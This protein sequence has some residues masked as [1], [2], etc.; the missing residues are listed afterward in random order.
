M[1]RHSEFRAIATS[2]RGLRER[3]PVQ[4]AA[5]AMASLGPGDAAKTAPRAMMESPPCLSAPPTPQCAPAARC[6]LTRRGIE[7]RRAAVAVLLV[8]TQAAARR[9]AA[10]PRP[11]RAQVARL[12]HSPE[13]QLRGPRPKRGVGVPQRSHSRCRQSCCYLLPRPGR[14][15]RRYCDRGCGCGLVA[16]SHCASG[17]PR[18]PAVHAPPFSGSLPRRSFHLR[19]RPHLRP[20]SRSRSRLLAP[21]ASV[22]IV[23]LPSRC[24]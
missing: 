11:A 22:A 13:E 10:V 1:W 20:R 8:P 18:R 6:P 19:P 3:S 2:L 23:T 17:R 21:A 14:G 12:L 16:G 15:C 24:W 5:T 4:C 9:P 7:S